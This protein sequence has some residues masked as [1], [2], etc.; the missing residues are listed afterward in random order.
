MSD[1]QMAARP[2]FVGVTEKDDIVA[3]R[4]AADIAPQLGLGPRAAHQA[5][6]VGDAFAVIGKL[7]DEVVSDALPLTLDLGGAR[8]LRKRGATPTAW[9]SD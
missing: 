5:G 2:V 7:M 6:Q 1:V 4:G 3:E 9:G 8:R